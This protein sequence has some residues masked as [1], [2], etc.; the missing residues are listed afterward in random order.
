[1]DKILTNDQKD[2]IT[3]RLD[4]L[5]LAKSRTDDTFVRDYLTGKIDELAKQWYEHG[6][7]VQE[8][9]YTRYAEAQGL[10]RWVA[11]EYGLP[12]TY[13][14]MHNPVRL[15][16]PTYTYT[17]TMRDPNLIWRNEEIGKYIQ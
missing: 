4:A 8:E 17:Y 9:Q 6:E 1:M 13:I 15:L 12:E 16:T 7:G 10:L 14:I 2:I 11:K 3:E 5:C